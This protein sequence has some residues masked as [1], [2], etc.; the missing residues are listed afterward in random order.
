MG[1]DMTQER[2][3]TLLGVCIVPAVIEA[4]QLDDAGIDTFYRSK[5]YELLGNVET[6]MWHF[7]PATLAKMFLEEQARGTFEIPE[8]CA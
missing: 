5:L 4:A 7:S 3:S 6:G 8:V 2:L 1:F